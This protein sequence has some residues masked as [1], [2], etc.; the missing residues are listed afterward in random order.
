MSQEQHY[1]SFSDL[2]NLARGPD[3]LANVGC[4]EKSDFYKKFTNNLYCHET[5]IDKQNISYRVLNHWD[6]EGLLECIKDSGKGWRKFNLIQGFWVYTIQIL[7]KMGLSFES[8]G[9]VKRS[10]FHPNFP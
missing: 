1:A 4:F 9:K 8:L 5:S 10:I 6:E 7:R 3:F 2:C